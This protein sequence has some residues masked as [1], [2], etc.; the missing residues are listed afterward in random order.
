MKVALAS[1]LGLANGAIAAV[2]GFD[3]SHYQSSVN[4]AS[5]YSAGA[6]FVIIKATEGTTYIDP[7]FSSHY[8]GA[9][10]AGLIRGGYHFA[11]L[12]WRHSGE[13]L[14]CSRRWL[15]RRWYHTPRYA[16]S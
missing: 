13:L 5:A 11:H 7:S 10:N 3:I 1:V 14:P 2:Q 8:T 9:T 16:R 4:F 15:V 6:R 12:L